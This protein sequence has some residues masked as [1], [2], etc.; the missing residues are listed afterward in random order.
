VT[1]LIEIRD[2][3]V[4][5]EGQQLLNGVNLA[6]PEGQIH[7]LLGPNGSGKTSLMMTIMG[8]PQYTVTRG[9]ILF[10]GQDITGLDLTARARLGIGMAHQRP[11][12][13]NGVRLRQ[14]VD[15]VVGSDAQLAGELVEWIRDAR[16]APFLERQIN[17]GLSGGEIKRSELLQMLAMQP[18]FVLLDE[19]D[20]GVDVDALDVVSKMVNRLLSIDPDRPVRRRAGLVISHTGHI[21]ER[22][23]AD[24]AHVLIDGRIVCSGHPRMILDMA[25]RSGYQACAQCAAQA[26]GS[27]HGLG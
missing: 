22:V 25:C 5:I 3:C 6:I 17:A 15:Y 21:L 10:A 1:E 26:K 16:M 7:A 27:Q 14:V 19:P 24:R 13:V 23:H 11:P 18:R 9:A 4:H 12:T 8:Y 20:S 2:L